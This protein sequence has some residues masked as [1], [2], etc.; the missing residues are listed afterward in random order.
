MSARNIDDPYKR[1]GYNNP[2][3]YKKQRFDGKKS[4]C[5]D[6]TGERIFYDRK[7]HTMKTATDVDHVVPLRVVKERYGDL[8]LAQQKALANNVSN[9]AMT[10]AL[11]NERKDIGKNDLQNHEFVIREAGRVGKKVKDNLEKGE[12]A[13]TGDTLKAFAKTSSRMLYKEAQAETVMHVQAAG[14]RTENFMTSEHSGRRLAQKKETKVI[15]YHGKELLEGNED[16]AE[17]SFGMVT[18]IVCENVK[19]CVNQEIEKGIVNGTVKVANTVIEKSQ[20]EAVKHFMTQFANKNTVSKIA[21]LLVTVGANVINFLNSNMSVHDLVFN[22]CKIGCDIAF[23]MIGGELL[24][25][26]GMCIGAFIGGPAGAAVGLVVGEFVGTLI[27]SEVMNILL[28]MESAGDVFLR[29]QRELVAEIDRHTYNM[30]QYFVKL[31]TEHESVIREGMKKIVNG[32]L[33]IDYEMINFGIGDICNEFGFEI[34]YDRQEDFD[35]FMLD[36]SKSVVI[37]RVL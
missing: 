20:N 22:V 4:M 23:S 9:Y 21:N 29:A 35:S 31:H 14:Y 5:D 11:L 28:R 33:S 12:F 32:I 19:Q 30:M 8:T 3:S 27:G 24:G 37:S 6:Y 17:A 34:A 10:N 13:E 26:A 7:K 1:I 36:E 25:T 15:L 16:L 18:D 2:N